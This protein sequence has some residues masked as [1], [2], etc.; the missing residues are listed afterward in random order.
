MQFYKNLLKEFLLGTIQCAVNAYFF[1]AQLAIK[2]A[3]PVQLSIVCLLNS[4]S[5]NPAGFSVGA[6]SSK[7]SMIDSVNLQLNVDSI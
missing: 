2:F 5:H 1:N 4:G 3:L 7:V 6:F